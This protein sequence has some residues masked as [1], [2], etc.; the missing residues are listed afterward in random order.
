MTSPTQQAA[1]A[2]AGLGSTD[3]TG[4]APADGGAAGGSGGQTTATS[5]APAGPPN[6]GVRTASRADTA[7]QQGQQAAQQQTQQGQQAAQQGDTGSTDPAGGDAGRVEDLPA[8]A[9]REIQHA[10]KGE[11]DRR[12]SQRDLEKQLAD[13]D[14]EFTDFKARQEQLLEGVAK[15]F[16]LEGEAGGEGGQGQ[17]PDPEKLAAELGTVQQKHR[18]TTVELAVYRAAGPLGANPDRLLDSRDFAGKVHKLDPDGDDFKDKVA[19]HIKAAV[20]ADPF[21]KA[22]GQ[23]PV[24]PPPSGGQFAG[25]PG[26]STDPESMSVDDFRKR[27]KERQ[28]SN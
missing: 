21:F 2:A 5:A 23:A 24:T 7:P 26:A 18:E 11:A 9:Q 12:R 16:G 1:D 13:R 3:T 15:L 8:W 14:K 19:E 10:R 28:P 20:K 6:D 4:Q 27:R 25:G 22:A 17:A